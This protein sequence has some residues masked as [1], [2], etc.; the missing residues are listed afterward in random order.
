MTRLLDVCLN[1]QAQLDSQTSTAFDL[2]L[3]SLKNT[4]PF[5]IKSALNAFPTLLQPK[6]LSVLEEG[7]KLFIA[8]P[9]TNS[10]MLSLW[11]NT[12]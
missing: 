11:A 12:L 3:R 7:I 2:C 8:F 4:Y 9:V 5:L 10:A 6:F 1:Q